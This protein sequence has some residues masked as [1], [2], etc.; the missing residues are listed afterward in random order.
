MIKSL[1]F[2]RYGSK[3]VNCGPGR[4]RT[5][6]QTADILKL[7]RPKFDNPFINSANSCLLTRLQTLFSPRLYTYNRLFDAHFTISSA[8]AVYMSP[9]LA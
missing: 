4:V 5:C 3:M 9:G 6:D 2:L 7:S 1:N 8:G